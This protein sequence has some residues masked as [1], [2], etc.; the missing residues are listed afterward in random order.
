ML[1]RIVGSKGAVSEVMNGKRGISKNMAIALSE[2][3]NVDA[4]LFLHF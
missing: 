3:F 4:G 1:K 2:R